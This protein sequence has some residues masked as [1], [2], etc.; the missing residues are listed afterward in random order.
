MARLILI[1]ATLLQMGHSPLRSQLFFGL[2]GFDCHT[3]R[4]ASPRPRGTADKAPVAEPSPPPRLWWWWFNKTERII[5]K[6][7]RSLVSLV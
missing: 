6:T 3:T 5:N 1:S 7:K 4:I 2:F